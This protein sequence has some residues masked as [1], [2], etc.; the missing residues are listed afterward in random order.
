MSEKIPTYEPEPI[1]N[2]SNIPEGREGQ[3]A[4]NQLHR[5]KNMPLLKEMMEVMENIQKWDNS[6]E[7]QQKLNEQLRELE[8]M[9]APGLSSESKTTTTWNGEEVEATPEMI[10]RINEMKEEAF[11]V[12][13]DFFDAADNFFN[14]T[15]ETISDIRWRELSDKFWSILG[16]LGSFIPDSVQNSLSDAMVEQ[17]NFVIKISQVDEKV[18]W[19][20]N[21]IYEIGEELEYNLKMAEYDLESESDLERLED[22]E[23]LVT[24][25]AFPI[26]VLI[27]KMRDWDDK[28]IVEETLKKYIEK[29]NKHLQKNDI[30]L[31][32]TSPLY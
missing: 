5:D 13:D 17:K 4:R 22:V 30:D 1:D 11:D 28:E 27:G 16:I 26:D 14:T 12:A 18:P 25:I 23:D 8:L 2:S 29:L 10:N 9:L 21:R 20:A 15:Q 3:A 6:P 19:F 32:D 24:G 7:E 31:I